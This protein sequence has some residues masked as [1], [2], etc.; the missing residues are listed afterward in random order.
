MIFVFFSTLLIGPC[1]AA[2][3]LDPK[4]FGQTLSTLAI[5]G[6]GTNTLQVTLYK[7]SVSLFLVCL[8]IYVV[9]AGFIQ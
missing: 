1:L 3:I 9:Q 2:D 4:K 8:D 5:D 6:L 7:Y